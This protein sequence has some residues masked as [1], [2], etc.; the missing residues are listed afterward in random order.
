M[1]KSVLAAVA[2]ACLSGNALAAKPA[3]FPSDIRIARQAVENELARRTDPGKGKPIRLD[4]PS[5]QQPR[6]AEKAA[7]K[8]VFGTE[9]PLQI[10]RTGNSGK[11]IQY[12]ATLPAVDYRKDDT[13]VTWQDANW[14]YSVNGNTVDATLRWPGFKA[15]WPDFNLDVA[16]IRGTT[17]QT[18]GTLAHQQQVQVG[19][20]DFI[21][22]KGHGRAHAEELAVRE[23]TTATKNKLDQRI[24]FS[25]QRLRFE[26]GV[27]LDDLHADL[28]LRDLNASLWQ[29]LT[30]A[31]NGD[32]DTVIR[33]LLKPL[34]LQGARLELADLSGTFGGGKIRLHGSLGM[35]GVKPGDL[36]DAVAAFNAVEA[37]LHVELPLATLRSFAVLSTYH[38]LK[39]PGAQVL[40]QPADQAYSYMLGKLLGDG[41]AR[42]EKDQLVADIDIQHNHITINGRAQPYTLIELLAKLHKQTRQPPEDDHTLPTELLWRDRALEQLLLFGHNGDHF[43]AA[44]LCRRYGV[45]GDA[46][47]AERWCAKAGMP[48]PSASDNP[49]LEAPVVFNNRSFHDS[50]AAG[51][52]NLSQFRF[53][54]SKAR[55]MTVKLSNPQQHAQ[56]APSI[57]MCISAEAPSDRACLTLSKYG[58]TDRLRASSR[59]YAADSRPLGEGHAL[60]RQFPLGEPVTLKLY[61]DERQAH[62]LVD[63]QEL[64]EGVTFPAAML[65]LSCS[66][67]DCDF[68]FD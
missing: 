44:E 43:A 40:D 20:V 64:L 10:K 23:E 28:R 30:E 55:G 65:L 42:L 60:E 61:V 48:V 47:P 53:D 14:Q 57:V 33:K 63:G 66:S 34:M 7:L 46:D 6:E 24:E 3:D 21:E 12:R 31:A 49:Q 39:S 16:D 19:S 41:Y 38:A 9:Q 37:H 45:A 1:K 58:D 2:A 62:F 27:A 11:T 4:Q 36:A 51:R 5:G 35:P 17:R 13:R 25:I 54:A 26:N 50:A 18:R 29:Q 22:T 15:Y 8:A 52:F 56:W 32:E 59:L 68:T 67:G